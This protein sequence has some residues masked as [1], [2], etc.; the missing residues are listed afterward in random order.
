MPASSYDCRSGRGDPRHGRAGAR[1]CRACGQRGCAPPG[2]ACPV[3]S[4]GSTPTALFAEQPRRRDRSAGRRVRLLRPRHGRHRRVPRR[5]HRAVGAGHGDRP[6]AGQGLDADRCRLD[7]DVARPRHG[8]PG[9]WTRAT[10]WC[11]TC[12]AG[13]SRTS[14]WSGAN[15]EHGIMAHRSGRPTARRTCRSAR[16]CASCRTTPAPPRRSTAATR[17]WDRR[18]R[19]IATWPRFSGW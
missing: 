19:S 11:A 7:G 2:I 4:V 15:Q 14:S 10:A 17:C 3:V 12:T 5:R 9:A 18:A 13:R 8:R 6:P 16:R 1:R